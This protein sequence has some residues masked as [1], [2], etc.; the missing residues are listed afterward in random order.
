MIIGTEAS[1]RKCVL[2]VFIWF[3]FAV[4]SGYAAPFTK[5]VVPIPHEWSQ[6]GLTSAFKRAGEAGKLISLPDP[7][8]W[9][10]A[11]QRQASDSKQNKEFEIYN[12]LRNENGLDVFI[13][14]DP[15]PGR[16]G[17][18]ANLPKAIKNSS[19]SDPILRKAF[20]A[21]ALNR[22][23]LY[24][25]KHICLAMEINAY[26][27]QHPEDFSNF[28]SLFRET[29]NRIKELY[30]DTKVL[31][32]YQFEQFLGRFGGQGDQLRHQPHWELLGMFE[33]FS[34]AV[35]ISSYP[36]E[37]YAPLKFGAPG[38]LPADYYA[39]IARHTSK[40][41][42][43]TELGWP[44]AEKYGGSPE[45]QAAFIT[46][47]PTLLSNLN[48]DIVNWFFLS[49]A[50]GFGDLFKSMGLVDGAGIEKPAFEAWKNL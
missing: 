14:L 1:M 46:R 29:R 30:P 34:D 2:G 5:S 41:I 6:S 45:R 35:G 28:V 42:V 26:Y 22:M 24:R 25:P 12:A 19:F 16:R 11:S 18:I 4:S 48:V 3:L 38:D 13:Q 23:K 47:L 36:M 32:S 17:P 44:S 33:S 27:E 7:V 9:F 37:S 39:Q 50:D 10:D 20:I 31:V 21:D 15:Y 40:P 49:D 8:D 43:F